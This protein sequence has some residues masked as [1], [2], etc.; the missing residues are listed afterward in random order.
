MITVLIDYLDK[1]VVADAE[2]GDSQRRA[3]SRRGLGGLNIGHRVRLWQ[4][5][6]HVYPPNPKD[7]L[8]TRLERLLAGRG[9]CPCRR[10]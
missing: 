1:R 4:R 9:C 10:R 6:D 5:Q 8:A 2:A 3:T 7:E